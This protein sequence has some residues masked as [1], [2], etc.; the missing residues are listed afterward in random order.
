MDAY[1]PP[2]RRTSS[3]P[4]TEKQL[5]QDAKRQVQLLKQRRKGAA[6][7]SESRA[8]SQDIAK[9]RRTYELDP[10]CAF[11][12]TS[13]W[14]RTVK[15]K[16]HEDVLH[17]VRLAF[18]SAVTAD[19]SGGYATVF[20]NSPVQAQNW[21]NYAA[22]FDSY[23]VLCYKIT[24]EPFWTVNVTF[25]P[26]ASVIDRSDSTA[27]TSYGLAER[28]DSH[29]KAAGKA[30]WTQMAN[31]SGVSTADF[32]STASPAANLW[33]KTYSSGNTASLT[34]GRMNC[35]MLVQFRGV[36]IN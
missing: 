32:V 30:A 2:A 14:G 35:E 31:M 21:A 28:Y 25:A 10:E 5:T 8:D 18:D 36:G 16:R 4:K 12:P 29:H 24:F 34:F 9:F 19:G 26:M 13:E 6:A 27:L 33:I 22:V 20:S 1:H 7:K 17:T 23:R 11:F 15:T 3:G